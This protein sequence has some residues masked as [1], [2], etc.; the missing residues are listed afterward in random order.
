MADKKFAKGFYGKQPRQGA[1]DYVLGSISIKTE[2]A[3]QWLQDNTN[4]KGY[5][6]LDILKGKEDKLNI[7]LNEYVP[8]SGTDL[9]F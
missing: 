8:K 4:S 6:N 2:D 5:V 1:P 3:I 9:P 7:S